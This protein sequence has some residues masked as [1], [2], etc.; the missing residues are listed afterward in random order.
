MRS[1]CSVPSPRKDRSWDPQLGQRGRD[2]RDRNHRALSPENPRSRLH[3]LPIRHH[4]R[5][6]DLADP[7]CRRVVHTTTRQDLDDIGKR[8]RLGRVRGPARTN[9]QRQSLDESHQEI[10]RR[11]LLAD[12]QPRPHGRHGNAVGTERLFDFQTAREM[13]RDPDRWIRREQPAEIHDSLHARVHRRPRKVVSQ[14]EV[15]IFEFTLREPRVRA[16]RMH[17]IDGRFRARERLLGLPHRKEVAAPHPDPRRVE[18]I[19]RASVGEVRETSPE[20][21]HGGF[22]FEAARQRR[23]DEARGAG[24]G[25]AGRRGLRR[26]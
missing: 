1:T 21:E 9:H 15:E 17:Q 8:D 7:P 22:R 24:D 26:R 20:R 11:P 2:E 12:D 18:R 23:A 19:G 6:A 4:F 10:Q 3:H 5:P 13:R 16:H 25:D 14:Q